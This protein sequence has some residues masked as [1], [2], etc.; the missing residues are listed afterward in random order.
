MQDFT[1]TTHI[2]YP[3]YKQLQYQHM[4]SKPFMRVITVLGMLTVIAYVVM[5]KAYHYNLLD[6]DWSILG[7]VLVTMAVY[8]PVSAYFT[9]KKGFRRNLRLQE[10]ITYN[11]SESGVAITGESF[12]NT[13]TWVKLYKV[14]YIS[15]WLKLYHNLRISNPIKLRESDMHYVAELKEFLQSRHPNVKV[16]M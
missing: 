11:F 1:I 5:L 12:T 16:E 8:A 4:Y 6:S 14:Q 7:V 13:F 15:G 10:T 3:E 2:T 9:I